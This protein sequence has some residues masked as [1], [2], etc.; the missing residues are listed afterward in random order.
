MAKAKQKT[1]S[2]PV[3]SDDVTTKADFLELQSFRTKDR[4]VSLQ[5]LTQELKRSGSV[6]A[7]GDPEAANY[8]GDRGTETSQS[9]AEDTFNEL[10]DRH[11]AC[12]GDSGQYPFSVN[13]S[14]LAHDNNAAGR[15]YTFLLL[16]SKFG[17]T[18]GP[19]GTHGERIFEDL[20]RH[21]A[22]G[23]FG[24]AALG[25]S[26]EHFGFP[27]RVLPK[28]F[29]KALQE[30]SNR[31]GDFTPNEVAPR[32]KDQKDAK[33]DIVAWRPFPDRRPGKLIGFGQCAAGRA[34]FDA[35]IHELQ[36]QSFCKSW[37]REHPSVDPVRMFFVPWRVGSAEYRKTCIDGGIAF[38]RCRISYFCGDIEKQLRT[39][40]RA[41]SRHVLQAR[42]V[43]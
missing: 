43:A 23:Y 22:Q 33:L 10:E 27:R 18:A 41:W 9:L 36:I 7:V 21:A 3:A 28:H 5:D 20:C 38:D 16:L 15:V 35:K 37:L 8:V 29:P 12:G 19:K 42:L 11:R 40:C 34:D 13:G 1:L 14:L 30:L 4:S 2:S 39:Q 25:A 17:I 26:A 6:D 24:G 32:S 31:V